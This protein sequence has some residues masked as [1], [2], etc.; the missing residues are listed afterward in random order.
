MINLFTEIKEAFF[1]NANGLHYEVTKT[2]VDIESKTTIWLGSRLDVIARARDN[3]SSN[4]GLLVGWTD[5]AGEQHLIIIP[6]AKLAS[7]NTDSWLPSLAKD[8]YIPAVGKR[9]KKFLCRFL[10]QYLRTCPAHQQQQK[11]NDLSTLKSA[12]MHNL[13]V[14]FSLAQA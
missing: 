5:P 9:E 13:I 8:G 4:W 10:R 3:N 14:L 2:R 7:G 6:F 1:N 12:N 11:A